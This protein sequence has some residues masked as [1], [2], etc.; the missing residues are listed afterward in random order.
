MDTSLFGAALGDASVLHD[1]GPQV[2]A[3]QIK[4]CIALAILKNSPQL[5]LPQP[6]QVLRQRELAK[7]SFREQP[8]YHSS[9][10]ARR[11]VAA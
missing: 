3:A 1:A 11:A 5:L 4:G 8:L 2:E 10:R 6:L 9:A 7:Q